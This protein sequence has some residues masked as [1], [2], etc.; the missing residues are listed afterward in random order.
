MPDIIT[1]QQ[2]SS[3]PPSSSNPI[4][5]ELNTFFDIEEKYYYIDRLEELNNKIDTILRISSTKE[6]ILSKHSKASLISLSK[7]TDDFLKVAYN[8]SL[9]S[10]KSFYYFFLDVLRYALSDKK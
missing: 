1:Q 5:N 8:L 4:P 6:E 7:I 2:Q 10:V 3:S 9:D